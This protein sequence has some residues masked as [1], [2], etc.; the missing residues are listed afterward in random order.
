MIAGARTDDPSAA[1]IGREL[2]EQIQSTANLEGP[3]GIV[4]LVLDPR[5]AAKP[6]LQERMPQ[7]RRALHDGVDTRA[8]VEHV[9]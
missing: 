9:L 1:L 2:R 6:L 3:G 8:R 4:V 5:L 7:Q